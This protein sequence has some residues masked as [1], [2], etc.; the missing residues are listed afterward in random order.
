M[1]WRH[2][3]S[4]VL[5]L[6]LGLGRAAPAQCAA[7]EP[8]R[9][10]LEVDR[11][12]G[13]EGCPSAEEL[14]LAVETRLR[15]RIFVAED[16]A[17]LLVEL[18]AFR[19]GS[20]YVVLIT[21][22]DRER[23]WLGERRLETG[24]RHC[25]ALDDS[26]ALVLS[27]AADVRR[28][29][30][31]APAAAAPAIED[32]T[33]AG[34]AAS[35]PHTE[36]APLSTPL[37]IPATTPAPRTPFEFQPSLG[38]AFGLGLL[39]RLA[40]GAQARLVIVPPELWPLVVEGTLWHPQRLGREHGVDFSLQTLRVGLCPVRRAWGRLELALCVDPSLGVMRTR[41]FGFDEAS[42]ATHLWAALGAGGSVRYP[43]GPLFLSGAAS[44]LAPLVQ[45]RYFYADE[46]TVT[47]HRAPWLLGVAAI[48]VG[49]D[50]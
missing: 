15:R 17:D 42:A 47:L 40:W 37:L 43:I 6:L 16:Q 30:A 48:S 33:E 4:A 50:L 13:A 36:D 18:S 9:V 3:A 10:Y 8:A 1:S 22:L 39:P 45:R 21:L 23:R 11:R 2:I 29:P 25:S 14:R 35:P 26:L 32:E 38:S 5:A 28:A 19:E 27:L 41:G 44:L 34:R 31:Q 7:A 24:A 12:S 46:E 20:R 49:I